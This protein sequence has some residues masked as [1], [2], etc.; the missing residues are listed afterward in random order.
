M[1]ACLISIPAYLMSIMKF[2]KWAID[3]I[4]SQMSHFCWGNM[5]DSHK[6]HL[7]NWG[8]ISR[9]KEFGGMGVP[10]LRDFNMALLASWGKRFFDDRA[11]DWKKILAYKYN[12][13]SPNFFSTRAT[14]GS[15]FV[16]SLSWALA[17][18]KNFYMWIPADGKSIAF[19]HDICIGDCSLKTASWDLYDIC[20]Q[21]ESTL[22][23]VWVRRTPTYL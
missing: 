20:Q 13:N 18:A 16:K 15:P 22:A 23:Q 2:P 11:S 4:T 12:I 17:A 14:L 7:A 8:L 9:R 5:G 1:C 19:W 6:Y 21:Q 10:N 3:M